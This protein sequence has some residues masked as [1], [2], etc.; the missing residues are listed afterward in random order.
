MLR[1]ATAAEILPFV[2]RASAY[3]T[4]D[5]Q[6]DLHAI[7]ANGAA[8][9]LLE[10]GAPVFGYTL[11]AD[12]DDL[13]ITAAAGQAEHDLTVIGLRVIERQAARF[14]AV[15]FETIRP[16][17]VRKARRL[18]YEITRRTGKVYCMRKRIK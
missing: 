9:V 10:E 8:F 13:L 15:T 18:G 11:E 17:L 4:T 14:D 12:G 3:D 5:G 16:G 1:R 2:V 7:A 6:L